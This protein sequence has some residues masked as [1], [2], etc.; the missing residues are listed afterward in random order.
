M[1]QVI[2]QDQNY[3]SLLGAKVITIGVNPNGLNINKNCGSTYP[4]NIRT[5]SKKI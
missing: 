2:K 3:L 5:G 4:K 1:A